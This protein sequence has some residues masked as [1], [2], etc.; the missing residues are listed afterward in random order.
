MERMNQELRSAWN[1]EAVQLPVRAEELSSATAA[2]ADTVFIDVLRTPHNQIVFG[3]RGT[4]K[5]HLLKRLEEEYLHTFEK[6]RTVPAL[7]NGT[8][9]KQQA[10]ATYENPELIALALYTEFIKAVATR[11]H[12]FINTRLPVGLLDKIV[13]G[14]ET[15]IAQRARWLAETLYEL[16]FVLDQIYR[17]VVAKHKTYLFLLTN[18]QTDHPVIRTLWMKRM[19]HKIPASYYDRSTDRK[20]TY[21]QMDYANCVDFLGRDAAAKG[22][23]NVRKMAGQIDGFKPQN[24][25]ASAVTDVVARISAL[26]SKR[27]A[28]AKTP[29]GNP[30][31]NPTDIMVSDELVQPASSEL[32]KKNTPPRRPKRK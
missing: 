1:K 6:S 11:I 25:L 2:F 27:Q 17:N 26:I 28:L 19:I 18:T 12:K 22:E 23:A 13:R 14:G 4:G 24:W 7:I 20:Y 29:A 16:L 10:I 32:R 5:T 30:S 3:R 9:L 8:T 21:Y 15:K 31:P